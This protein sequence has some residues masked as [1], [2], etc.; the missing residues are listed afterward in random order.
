MERA[1]ADNGVAGC[2]VPDVVRI[3]RTT[4][5]GAFADR[6]ERRDIGGLQFGLTA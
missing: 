5:V 4:S 1:K 3:E 2:R 6:D